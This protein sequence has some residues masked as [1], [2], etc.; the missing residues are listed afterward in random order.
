MQF[1]QRLLSLV[2]YPV[3]EFRQKP[4]DLDAWHAPCSEWRAREQKT[5][6]SVMRNDPIRAGLTRR[7]ALATAGA[8]ALAASIPPVRAAEGNTIRVAYPAPVA[9]LDPAKFR[10][11]GLEYNYAHCVFNR[12]TAQDAKLQVIPELAASWEATEDLKVW[13][14]HLRPDVKFHNGKPFSADDVVFTYRRLMDKEVGSVLRAALGVVSKVEAVDPLTVRFTLS[15]PYS[16]LAAV[17][18][19]Y[20]AQIVC[21]AAMDTLTTKPVGTGPFRFVEY[22]PGDQLVVEKNPDY[23]VAGSPKVDRAILR[24]IPEYTTAVAGLESGAI[25]I[26]YDLPPEQVDLAQG[27]QGRA[28]GGGF[29]RHLARRRLQQRVQAVRRSA[30][31]RGLHQD[32]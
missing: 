11:G 32:R 10:V 29:D 8:T 14:F 1:S 26:V 20:Q 5:G 13:T 2:A 30:R 6:A 25:D 3:S 17:T 16:D 21:E 19:Q 27:Q 7:A 28:G 23:F 22:R 24:I 31:A 9:T 18:A 4:G 12:L 15:A